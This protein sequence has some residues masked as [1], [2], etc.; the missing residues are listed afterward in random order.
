MEFNPAKE[1]SKKDT[2]VLIRNIVENGIVI[3]SRHAKKRMAERG[4]TT[5][6]VEFILTHGNIQSSEFDQMTGNWK[7]RFCGDDLDG[8]TGTVI[9]A[10]AT[11]KRSIVI[12]VLG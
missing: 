7:Y 8:G 3:I 2:A 6:D 1:L 12:T 5:Q 4:Y 10:I 11:K 9:V